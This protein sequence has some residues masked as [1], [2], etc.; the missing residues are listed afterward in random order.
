M[1]STDWQQEIAELASMLRRYGINKL[2]DD[3][4][5]ASFK[6]DKNIQEN[7]KSLYVALHAIL[8][9]IYPARE[10]E[11]LTKIANEHAHRKFES[12]NTLPSPETRELYRQKLIQQTLPSQTPVTT[13]VTEPK[14]TT[15]G[16]TN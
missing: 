14:D 2:P 1:A 7:N 6:L 13:T 16:Q 4:A 3:I 12:T 9:N 15:P 11:L 5:D 8:G 10:H